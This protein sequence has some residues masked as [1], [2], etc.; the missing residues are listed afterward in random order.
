MAE[1]QYMTLPSD[2]S[3]S[4]FPDNTISRYTTKLAAPLSFTDGVY[5][6]GL[7]DFQYVNS[8]NNV[9]R[10]EGYM[11]IERIS[12]G[13]T[14][15]AVLKNGYYRTPKIL[16]DCI[17]GLTEMNS[18]S[19]LHFS[20]DEVTQKVKVDVGGNWAVYFSSTLTAMLGLSS[21]FLG[22]GEHYADLVVDVDRG[23][24]AMYVYCS[25]IK[26]CIVGDTT[27]QL[28]RVVPKKG[29]HGDVVSLSFNN[30]QFHE[31]QCS[32]INDITINITMDDGNNVPFERGKCVATL[33]YRK[34]G[35]SL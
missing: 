9:T 18:L 27:A 26:S 20:L 21:H 7:S 6:I 24:H 30:I 31:V 19:D 32:N 14:Y 16:V 34:K 22:P 15:R 11:D 13:F 4:F 25:I 17:N 5:E 28:L 1:I 33:A 2:S 29:E 10:D 12:T 23:F 8:W 35:L 3:F